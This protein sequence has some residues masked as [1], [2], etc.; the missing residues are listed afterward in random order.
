MRVGTTLSVA[1]ALLGALVLGPHVAAENAVPTG[2]AEALSSATRGTSVQVTPTM[3]PPVVEPGD[4]LEVPA[5]S[6]SG[7]RVVYSKGIMRVWLIEEDGTLYDTH[8]V[9]GR[10]DQPNYGTYA[11]WSRSTFTCS[12]KSPDIC[13]RFM[14]RF[15]FA[16]SGDNIGFHEI[17]QR[18]G[19]PLQT[20]DQLGQA[21][22]GGCVRQATADAIVMWDWAQIG[23]VVVVVP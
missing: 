4:Q 16:R 6:G 10:L 22:S 11:V 23:T 2:G 7:R 12:R 1:A 18:R 5:N 20:D 9:S 15:A 17:P 19:V 21:L 13:M 14:V 3:P 8:R